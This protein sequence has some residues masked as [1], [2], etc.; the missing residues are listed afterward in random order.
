VSARKLEDWKFDRSQ[1]DPEQ[2][3]TPNLPDAAKLKPGNEVEK[4]TLVPFGATQ[5]RMSIFPKLG[6]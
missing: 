5:L 2:R 4:I 6:S 3:F 1:K